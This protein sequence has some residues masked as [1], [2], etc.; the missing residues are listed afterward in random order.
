MITTGFTTLHSLSGKQ[1]VDSGQAERDPARMCGM[2]ASAA[3]APGGAH[4]RGAVA[5][6]RDV[7]QARVAHQVSFLRTR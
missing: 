7:P 2:W 6:R 1:A 4:G 5:R 3:A